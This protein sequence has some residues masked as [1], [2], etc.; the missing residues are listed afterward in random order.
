M[1]S[2]PKLEKIAKERK[3]ARKWVESLDRSMLGAWIDAHVLGD[4]DWCDWFTDKPS[5]VFVNEAFHH[6]QY[7]GN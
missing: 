7:C 2:W 6:A 5:S 3:E 4:Y 1:G